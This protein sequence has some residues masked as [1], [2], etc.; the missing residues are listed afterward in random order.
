[1]F[2]QVI[3]GRVA[4]AKGL[5]AAMDR[6]VAELQPGAQGWLGSTGGFTD[7]GMF[8]STV[9]FESQEA[10]RRNS[11]R[12]EQGAW[13]AEAEKCF[14]GPVTFIDCPQ[15]ELWM[16]GG[17]DRAWFVQVMEGH[18]ADADRMKELMQRYTDEIHRM[19]PEIIGATVALHGDGAFVQTVYFT[20][21]EEARAHEN[22][23]PPPEMVQAM[24]VDQ[25]LMDDVTY[26]D[27]HHPWLVSP[28]S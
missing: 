5:Q 21:E 15:V 14:D 26:L 28:R 10:A 11:D 13:W 25:E 16:Q 2:I 23:A 6:W 19:R 17:S 24:Q 4:D 12:P 27:L 9:R 7:D 3:Q 22:M 1:M 18:T 20:S 8:V